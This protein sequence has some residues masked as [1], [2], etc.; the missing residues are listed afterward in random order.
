MVLTNGDE[1]ARLYS[2]VCFFITIP[3]VMKPHREAARLL[4]GN[5]NINATTGKKM[6]RG[7]LEAAR[8]VTGNHDINATTG[9][10]CTFIK[11]VTTQN[12]GVPY[13]MRGHHKV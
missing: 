1:L 10:G 12:E 11:G 5:D 3:D 8:L 9:I 13:S 4:T 2:F 6:E 7:C